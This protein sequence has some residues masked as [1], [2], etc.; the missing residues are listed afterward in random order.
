MSIGIYVKVSASMDET[1]TKAISSIEKNGVTVTVNSLKT[2][3]TTTDILSCI[4]LPSNADWIPYA[5]LQDSS[6]KT[7]AMEMQLVNARYAET[8]LSNSRCYHF[9]FPK[10]YA[11]EK[12]DTILFSI[13]KI[14]TTISESLTQND[15]EKAQAKLAKSQAGLEFSCILEKQGMR[16]EIISQPKG[17]DRNMA[18]MLA[19]DSLTETVDGPWNLEV[20]FP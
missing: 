3:K 20:K 6:G 12:Q 11:E 15:C 18:H 2:E 17:I 19:Y 13:E 9:I 4:T 8:A 5:V 16:I 14:Q 10:G 7:A 1:Q